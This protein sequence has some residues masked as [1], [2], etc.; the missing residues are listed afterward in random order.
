MDTQLN[1]S[2]FPLHLLMYNAHSYVIFMWCVRQTWK[3]VFG[4]N[5]IFYWNR[6]GLKANIAYGAV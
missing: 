4:H 2:P 3:T 6:V 1:V 5:N